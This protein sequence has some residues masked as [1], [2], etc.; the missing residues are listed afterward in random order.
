MWKFEDRISDLPVSDPSPPITH[1]C[2][3]LFLIRFRAA[4]CRP[5]A[6]RKSEHLADPITVPPSSIIPDT[7][8]HSVRW[9][10]SPPSIRPKFIK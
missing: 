9:I 1:K 6:L 8:Y 10:F 4:F 5:S 2:E 7:S 3:I